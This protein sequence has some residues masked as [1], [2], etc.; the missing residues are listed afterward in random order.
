MRKS[1]GRRKGEERDSMKY[2][3]MCPLECSPGTLNNTAG[4][5][6]VSAL[7]GEGFIHIDLC[8]RYG[9]KPLFPVSIFNPHIATIVLKER[10]IVREGEREMMM[11]RLRWMEGTRRNE[12]GK[13]NAH[14]DTK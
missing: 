7:S 2:V 9:W 10:D 13:E 4:L 3:M 8:V 1:A 6:K 5:V 14:T 11:M 12:G